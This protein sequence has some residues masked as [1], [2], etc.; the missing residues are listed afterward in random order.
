MRLPWRPVGMRPVCARPWPL[1]GLKL[2]MG[3]RDMRKVFKHAVLNEIDALGFLAFV[4]VGVAA[5]EP[6]FGRRSAQGGVVGDGEEAGQNVFADI[7]GEGLAFFVA[8]LA[9]AFEAVA[10]DFVEEDGGGASGENGGAVERLGDWGFAQSFET[11][12]QLA[13]GRFQFGLRR[14][15]RR[16]FRPQRSD[17]GIDPCRR[18]RG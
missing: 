2:A 13:D 14:A 6:V 5:A 4:V 10:E 7:F 15:G 11:F 16:W 8:A 17:R 12:A 9:L 3:R 18:R 1:D